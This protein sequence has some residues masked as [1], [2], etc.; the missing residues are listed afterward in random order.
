MSFTSA[1][2]CFGLSLNLG[3]MSPRRKR[4]V[5]VAFDV[6]VAR[7]VRATEAELTRSRHDAAE[8]VRR[9]HDDRGG[10]FVLGRPE[11]TSVVG[12][13][14]DRKVGPEQVFEQR[15]ERVISRSH[16]SPPDEGEAMSETRAVPIGDE[17]FTG[18][19]TISVHSPFNGAELGRVPSCGPEEV[20]RAVAAAKG[21]ATLPPWRRAEILD[22]AAK[23]LSE[24]V[25]EFARIIAEESAKPIRTARVEAERAVGTFVFSAVE[26]RKLVG[27]MVPLDAA[28]PG[29]GKLGFT[30]RVP[31]GVVGAISPFNFPL[32][33]VAHK[34]APA[35]AAGCPVVLKPASQTPFS[36]ITLAAD[37]APRV[38]SPARTSQ[39]GDRRRGH[40]RQRAG[41]RSRRRAHHVH[42]FARGRMGHQG[43]GASQARRPRA[44]QQRS[45]DHRAG[46]QLDGRGGQDPGRRVQP[47]RAVVHLDATH[48]RPTCPGRRLHSRARRAGRAPLSSA[49]HSTRRPRSRR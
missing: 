45:R 28:A 15:R 44:R 32:N 2:H 43:P 40:R 18:T 33:L 13:N 12:S 14:R 25:E 26:A 5:D 34:V 1:V 9:P 41:R 39:R 11:P 42:R 17:Q 35:I 21:A 7:D 47:C 19:D 22:A 8:G 3:M 36:A 4:L 49:T 27:E 6:E 24:R 23:R 10:R 31:I 30:L 46:R 16:G 29:E 38:W 37:V 20:R 48:L